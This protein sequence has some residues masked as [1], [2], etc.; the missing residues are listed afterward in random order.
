MTL[1]TP[2]V[3]APGR[4]HRVNMKMFR[5]YIYFTFNKKWNPTEGLTALGGRGNVSISSFFLQQG[6]ALDTKNTLSEA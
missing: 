1:L 3:L 4:I 2:T 6:A 5:I